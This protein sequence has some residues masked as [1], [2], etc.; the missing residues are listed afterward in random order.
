[1]EISIDD[2]NSSLNLSSFANSYQIIET[3]GNGAFGKVVKAIKK[4]TQEIVA[5]K[6]FS[7]NKSKNKYE[8]IITEANIMKDLNHINIVKYLGYFESGNNIYIVMEYLNGGTLKQYIEN[9]KDKINENISRI[10]IKQILSALSYLHYTCNIC[11]RDVKPE[12]IMFAEKDNI[13]S[14]K[15]LDFGLSTDN[16]ESKNYL[17][18]CGTLSYMAPEQISNKTYSKAVDIWSVGIILYMML[19]KGKNPFYNIGE[20]KETVIKRIKHEKLKFN[21]KENPM[22]KMAQQFIKKL[23]EKN[24]S[25][26]YTARPALNHPWITLNKYDKIPMTMYDQIKYIE[27][28]EK[29]KILLYAT[30]FIK[31]Q[32]LTKNRDFTDYEEY[33][34]KVNITSKQLNEAFK[35]KRIA[36]FIPNNFDTEESFVEDDSLSDDDNIVHNLKA[37]KTLNCHSPPKKKEGNIKSSK[38]LQFIKNCKRLP[39]INNNINKYKENNS[40]TNEYINIP[41]KINTIKLVIIG[42]EKKSNLIKNHINSKSRVNFKIDLPYLSNLKDKPEI[43]NRKSSVGTIRKLKAIK[44]RNNKKINSYQSRSISNKIRNNK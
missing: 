36:M 14:I 6:I 10:I 41:R 22:S 26:R 24:H 1:M 32:I 25:Y 27:Y 9:N 40:I 23:L 19:N 35:L 2:F 37:Y 39:D 18:N 34:K 20:S 15:L 16:F 17:L 3:I 30:F 5:V 38:T 31:S 44:D 28:I 12:N 13:N 21:I 33:E 8:N 43:Q 4:K 42:K 29:M 11:H 7:I